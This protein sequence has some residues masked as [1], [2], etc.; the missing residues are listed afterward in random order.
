MRMHVRKITVKIIINNNNNN[1]FLGFQDKKT[2]HPTQARRWDRD[3]FR[4]SKTI[5][6][7]FN[8]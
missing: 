4:V 2:H 5:I 6:K 8:H 7:H 1:N 3:R